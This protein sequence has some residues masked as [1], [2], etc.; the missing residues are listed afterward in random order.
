VTDRVPLF[1]P[2]VAAIL[3]VHPDSITRAVA[4]TRQRVSADLPLR[5]WDMPLPH[6]DGWW[7]SDV[8]DAYAAARPQALEGIHDP[9][10]RDPG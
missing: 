10:W 6:D 5:P 7:W 1:R 8:I 4:K 3:G 2:A 9:A